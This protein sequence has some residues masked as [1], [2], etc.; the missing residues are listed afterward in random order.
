MDPQ[1]PFEAEKNDAGRS[2]R[3]IA[4]IVLFVMGAMAAAGL[5]LALA[6]LPG[7]LDR[8]T[9]SAPPPQPTNGAKTPGR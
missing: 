7:R 1:L 5:V 6:T 9:E 3:S 8:G 4:R 2:N